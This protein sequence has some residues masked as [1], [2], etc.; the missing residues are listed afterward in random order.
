M[1]IVDIIACIHLSTSEVILPLT[2][3]EKLKI[4]IKAGGQENKA[5]KFFG[6]LSRIQE[7]GKRLM[8]T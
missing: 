1:L 2:K 5:K 3:H 7:L 6:S 4:I 8:H